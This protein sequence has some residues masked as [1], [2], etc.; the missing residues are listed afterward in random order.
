MN[1]RKLEL[2]TAISAVRHA[3]QLCRAVQS[4]MNPEALSKKDKSPVTVAD[5]GSQA[6]VL[7]ELEKAFP[8]DL[9]IAEEGAGALRD[10]AN[11]FLL[12]HLM[13]HVRRIDK[14]AGEEQ[15][16]GWIDRGSR[17]E[18]ADRFWTLD[19]IDGTKGFLRS[20]QYAISLALIENGEIVLGA[21]SCPNIAS[22]L[23]QAKDH[24]AVFTAVRGGGAWLCP[25][26]GEDPIE[27]STSGL[28]DP[29]RARF[30][31]SYE[32]G[33]SDHSWSQGVAE[34]LNITR[35]P[36]R[37][38]SQAKYAILASGAADLYLRLPTRA[39]YV[40][41]IWDHAAGVLIVEEAGGTVTDV[42]GKPLEFNHGY[43]L[44]KNRGVLVSGGAFHDRIVQAVK[45]VEAG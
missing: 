20:E 5:F 28:K 17:R 2:E 39:D 42:D 30:V 41:K 36:V 31:E 37:L 3:A 7:Y 11:R 4:E 21:L 6:I 14:D 12:A 38:D 32:S 15:V 8:K 33:H 29:S 44:T 35:D 26:G 23:P 45:E 1:T 24:D 27:L 43:L 25:G 9:M 40:E 10:P 19:P 18:N 13:D 22:Y 34:R 16:L